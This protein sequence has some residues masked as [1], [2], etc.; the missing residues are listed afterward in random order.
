MEQ[1]TPEWFEARKN[2][3]TGSKVGAILGLSPWQKPEDVLR[4]MVREYHGAESEFQGNIATEYGTV[5]EPNALM[6]YEFETGKTVKEAGF[7][8]YQHWLGASPDGFT[9]QGLVE[10]KCPYGLRNGGTFKTID[11]QPYYYAQMQIQM[12]VIGSLCK[13]CDF[14]Q[15]S[16]KLP[17]NI[18]TVRRDDH[19]LEEHLPVLFKFYE[20]YLSELE[21][22]EHLEPKRKE[23]RSL[24]AEKLCEEYFDLKDSIDLAEE[25][26]SAIIS[27]L[28][29]YSGGKNANINEYK[30]TK[31]SRKGSVSYAKVV[32]EHCKDVDLKPYTGKPSEYWK[33][34]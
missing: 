32:K 5:N 17:I 7:Y 10:F 18:V 28:E 34:S 30:L 13:E 26:Q 21:N 8:T 25:R 16:P 11:E 14:G 12:F 29:L 6:A 15:W 19:W 3:I 24:D 2:R 31:V 9:E 4:A 23:V 33:L 20:L 22:P 27:E 1:R